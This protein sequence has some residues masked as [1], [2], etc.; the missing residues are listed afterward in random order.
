MISDDRI[1][2]SGARA[3]AMGLQRG[4]SLLRELY[5]SGNRLNPEGARELA[6]A[7]AHLPLLEQLHLVSN[8]IGVHGMKAI[9][10]AF[11]GF[12]D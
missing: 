11:P 2:V 9:A 12:R 5:I 10:E 8:N 7:L 1:G 6:G 3:I 4:T